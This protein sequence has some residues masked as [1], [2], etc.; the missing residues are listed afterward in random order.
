MTTCAL[1]SL[2]MERM[3]YEIKLYRHEEKQKRLAL[4][5]GFFMCRLDGMRI[6]SGDIT[7]YFA[8]RHLFNSDVD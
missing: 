4:P 6:C 1:L 8:K 2:A 5:A 3:G 7:Y